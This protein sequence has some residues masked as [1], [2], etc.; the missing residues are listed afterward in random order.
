MNVKGDHRLEIEVKYYAM[1]RGVTGKRIEKISISKITSVR[2]LLHFLIERYG[3]ELSTFIYDEK[4]KPLDYLIFLLN[5][6]NIFSLDG[7]ETRLNE[8]D[9]F[10]F[11]PPLGGG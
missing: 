2:D 7:F 1:I 5:G 11:I 4:N 9:I 3:E 8:G 6:V 10:S